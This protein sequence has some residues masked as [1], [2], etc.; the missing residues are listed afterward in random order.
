MKLKESTEIIRKLV[1]RIIVTNKSGLK[2]SGTGFFVKESSILTCA[3]VAFGGDG[4]TFEQQLLA[5]KDEKL[6]RNLF[7]QRVSKIEIVAEDGTSLGKAV[8]NSFDIKHDAAIL[9]IDGKSKFTARH[10][11]SSDLDLG[12]KV[13]LCG[14]PFSIG[15]TN[16]L[17]YAFI[18]NDGIIAGFPSNSVGGFPVYTHFQVNALSMGGFSGA[19]LFLQEEAVIKGMINGHMNIKGVPIGIAY[20][21]ALKD[22]KVL[23]DSI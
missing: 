2:V 17:D 19:P 20:A 15:K 7:Q 9:T 14:F 11:Y 4:T 21:T 23:L 18:L 1:V 6:I 5:L 8:L 10:D 3:H 16:P 22:I 13:A 12:D